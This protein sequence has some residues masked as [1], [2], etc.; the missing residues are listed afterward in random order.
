[1]GKKKRCHKCSKEIIREEER[2]VR[3]GNEG[4]DMI[5]VCKGHVQICHNATYDSV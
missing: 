4:L 2:K 1:M 3:E 5:N